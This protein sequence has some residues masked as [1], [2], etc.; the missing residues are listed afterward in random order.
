MG[1]WGALGNGSFFHAQG[2]PT[3]VKTISG[4]VMCMNSLLFTTY[5][6]LTSVHPSVDESEGRTQPI[7]PIAMSVS[8]TGGHTLA[9]LSNA[10][11][12]L[13]WGANTS[14]QLG[15]G[16]RPNLPQPTYMPDFMTTY[17]PGSDPSKAAA[18][19]ELIP[20]RMS[21]RQCVVK[22]LLDWNGKSHGRNVKV[23]EWPVAG[24]KTSLI[25]WRIVDS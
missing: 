1:Q 13:A 5:R 17:S 21:L 2:T 23:R 24:G 12:V 16:K 3:K 18:E 4:N 10:H 22:Q 25:Y 19:Y 7:R 15:N 9:L 6:F 11:D 8:P 14:Y 20:E